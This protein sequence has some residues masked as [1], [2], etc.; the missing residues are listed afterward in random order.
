MMDYRLFGYEAVRKRILASLVC[1][2]AV[3]SLAA[4]DWRVSEAPVRFSVKLDSPPTHPSAGYFVHLPDGGILPRPFPGTR[5]VSG[6]AD[7]KSYVL[8]QNGES[9]LG[10]VF[11][12]PSRGGE[13]HIYVSAAR[14]LTTWTPASGLTPSAILCTHPERGSKGDAVALAKLGAVPWTVHYRNRPGDKRA[15]LSLP[16]DLSGR[17][18]PCALYMLAYVAT[19]D[20]GTTWIAPIAFSGDTEVRVDGKAIV[21][22]NR[23]NKAGGTGQYVELSEGV[24]RMELFGWARSSDTKN[25]L[26]TLTW[27][28]PQTTMAQLGGKRADDLPY[29]G[30]PMWDARPLHEGEIVRSG[31]ATVTSVASRDGQPLARISL[32]PI[33]NFWL[34]G[35]KPLLVYKASALTAGHPT[36]ARYEWSFGDGTRVAKPNTYWLFP[37]GLTGRARLTVTADGKQST[38]T[39]PFF[40]FTTGKTDINR[41]ACRENFR[42]AALDVFEAYPGD[43]DPTANWD[44][45]YWNNFFRN[46]EL[47][48]GRS[49]LMHLFRTRWDAIEP[50]LSPQRREQLLDI[51]LDFLPRID[52]D[53][54]IK[55]TGTLEK[56]SRDPQEAVMMQVLRAEMA[57]YYKGDPEAARRILEPILLKRGTDDASEWARIRYGDIDF[58]AGNLNDAVVL[59]GGVQDRARQKTGP[60]QRPVAAT[61]PAERLTTPGLARSKAEAEARR[62]AAKEKAVS[63]EKRLSA[64]NRSAAVADWKKNAVADAAASETVRSLIDQGYLLEAKQALRD[65]ERRFPLS[66]VSSDFILKEARFYMAVKEWSR[67]ETI[68]EA[69]C[70]QVDAS[71]FIPPAVEAL[72][73]CKVRLNEPED[74]LREFCTRMKKKLEYHPVGQEIDALRYKYE[75]QKK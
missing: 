39:L 56:R 11:E 26:M 8:W 72:L 41:P 16:G 61:R 2:V 75:L 63:A 47:D 15:P 42:R 44:A 3:A 5:V 37:G 55:W 40:P 71:S 50:K 27:K 65:W 32:A 31:Q 25:G 49:L 52:P 59:Y 9:G 7:V 38:C 53:M 57:L 21:A 74:S 4:P 70:E 48:K 30:T 19:T 36:S 12:T 62:A 29:P 23:T 28:T 43:K 24:H 6:N 13:V 35:E 73:E 17:S 68:L 45:S 22:E 54:A 51:F 64:L 67:A 60:G 34:G 14:Q 20:P 58:L 18:G 1:L 10:V 69:Y 66:K 46:M 33:E